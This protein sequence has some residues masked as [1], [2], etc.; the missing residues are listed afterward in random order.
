MYLFI[1]FISTFYSF[2]IIEIQRLKEINLPKPASNEFKFGAGILAL[3]YIDE[4]IVICAGY[5]TFIR[6]F[7]LRSNKW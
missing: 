5:D 3:S 4:N 7:D 6:V 1:I 2:Y